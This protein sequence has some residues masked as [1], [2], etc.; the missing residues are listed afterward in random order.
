[1]EEA[2]RLAAGLPAA[3][4]KVQSLAEDVD[5]LLGEQAE[6]SAHPRTRE[7]GKDAQKKQQVFRAQ[8][9]GLSA[10]ASKITHRS[11]EDINFAT[12]TWQEILTLNS[13]VDP[14]KLAGEDLIAIATRAREA[15]E[16]TPDTQ[17]LYIASIEIP[18][19]SLAYFH[20]EIMA[21]F[22]GRPSP[23]RAAL[24]TSAALFKAVGMDVAGTAIPFLGTLTTLFGLMKPRIERESQQMRAANQIQDRQ[25]QFDDQM[26]ALLGIADFVEANTQLADQALT[27]T[28]AYFDINAAWLVEILKATA[29]D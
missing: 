27:T 23:L 24:D 22:L 17:A 21:A 15:I 14:E 2:L 8:V 12:T 1:M 26:T 20:A 25:Y 6:L 13:K 5:R 10:V 4:E 3:L 7:I 11:K 29:R 18:L 9:A 19:Y 28:R 16:E